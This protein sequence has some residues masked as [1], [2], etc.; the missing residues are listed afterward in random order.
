MT[1]KEVPMIPKQLVQ[2]AVAAA[3]IAAA[4]GQIPKF[5][6]TMRVAQYQILK[7]SQASKWGRAMLLPVRK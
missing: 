2:A 6:Q 5:I 1:F 3:L 4:S 7:E